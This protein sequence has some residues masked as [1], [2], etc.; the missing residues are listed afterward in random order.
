VSGVI[1]RNVSARGEQPELVAKELGEKLVARDLKL[2]VVFADWRLD[3]S[4]FV[5]ALQRVLGRVPFVGCT[6]VGA[7]GSVGLDGPTTV[8]MGLYGDGL[9]VGVGVATE[10][11][12]HALVRSRDAFDRA[13]QALGFSCEQLDPT[14]HVAF[15]LA[16][17]SAGIEEAFCIGSA[18]AAPQIR[19]VGGAASTELDAR[20][21]TPIGPTAVWAHGEVMVDSGVAVLLELTRPFEAFTS[22]HLVPTDLKTV[23]TA[24]TGRTVEELDGIPA[25]R[26]LADLLGQIG[27]AFDA[28]KPTTYSFA[29]VIDG[30]PYVRS[31][32]HVEPTRI[33]LASSVEPGH[34]LRIMKPGDLLALTQR[35]L[36]AVKD[37]LGSIDAL[38]MF[39]CVHREWEARGRSIAP[40]LAAV[41][42]QYPTTGFHSFGE[43]TGM[44]FVNHTLTALA[45][46]GR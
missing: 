2:V 36:A 43:Q 14:R 6:A 27:V 41:Y 4:A 32:R 26:R 1:A 40:E 5:G 22:C 19:V 38:L 8:A 33:Q 35:D 24:S 37:R 42:D 31:I 11:S 25:P 16:E 18:A 44:L 21:A 10:L 15:T 9:R 23:V 30:V 29:R 46:G 12:K 13:A 7:V 45:I 34:V 17:G 39:S 20:G 28:N 3:P